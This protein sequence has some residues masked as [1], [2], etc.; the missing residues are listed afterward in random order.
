MKNVKSKFICFSLLVLHLQ[1]FPQKLPKVQMKPLGIPVNLKIDGKSKE[2]QNTFQAYN[3]KAE[4]FYT[5]SNDKDKFYLIVQAQNI[6]T[7]QKI[8]YGGIS[9][10]ISTSHLK[11]DTGNFEI[12]FPS[13]TKSY[14]NW[15]INV[16]DI[17]E[18]KKYIKSKPSTVDSFV[19]ISNK[20][21]DTKFKLIGVA[22]SKSANDS[23][24]FVYD[25]EDI[26]VKAKFDKNLFYT[27]ELTFPLNLIRDFDDD[28]KQFLYRI[29]VNGASYRNVNIMVDSERGRIFIK[30]K[31]IDNY[32]W[33]MTT[34]YLGLTFPTEFWSLYT[35][36]R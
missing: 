24:I 22:G 21:I 9:L 12:T 2:W 29:R 16:Q 34:K 14:S 20:Q 7:I 3:P 10:M 15:M 11:T 8:I 35:L 4:I 17:N 26:K 36:H 33:P 19:N 13:Y 23:L 6:E 25:N 31:N 32:V 18:I 1:V 27:Y 5:L 30:G 28:T